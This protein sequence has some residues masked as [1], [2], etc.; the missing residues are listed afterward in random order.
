MVVNKCNEFNTAEKLTKYTVK[1]KEE[2]KKLK[3]NFEN[4][5]ASRNLRNLKDS[6]TNKYKINWTE[7]KPEKPETLGTHVFNHFSLDEISRYIDWTPFFWTWELKGLYPKIFDNP[8][9]G[10]QAKQLFDE[11][12]KMLAEIINKKIF[13]PK[14]VVGFWKA[15][16]TTQP[17]LPT[18]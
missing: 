16:S 2:Q 3:E 12:Q 14:A 11:A 17:K 13:K 8:N 1:L 4:K 15:S 5:N 18:G 10:E 9:H 7:F 6:R